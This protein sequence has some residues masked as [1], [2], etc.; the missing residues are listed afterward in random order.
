MGT[1]HISDEATGG[2]CRLG[3][4]LDVARM[5]GAHLDNGNVVFLCQAEQRLGHAHVVIEI[6]LGI[7]H[8]VL[9]LKHVGNQFLRG[10]LAVGACDSDDRDMELATMFASQVLEGLE[11]VVNEDETLVRT[12]LIIQ[13]VRIIDDGV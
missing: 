6:A 2:L 10:G 12:I 9:L 3:Q 5:A 7:E 1:S 11:A 4:C 13:N 8:V